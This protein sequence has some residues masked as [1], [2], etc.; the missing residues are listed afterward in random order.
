[1]LSH[2]LKRIFKFKNYVILMLKSCGFYNKMYHHPESEVFVKSTFKHVL[3][4]IDQMD[5]VKELKY[6]KPS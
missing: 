1:M 5:V 4:V 6:E 2:C 3:I